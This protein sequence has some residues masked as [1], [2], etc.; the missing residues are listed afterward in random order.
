M[1]AAEASNQSET[2]EKVTVDDTLKSA[3]KAKDEFSCD[4]CDFTSNWANGLSI[5]MTRKHEKVEQLDGCVDMEED[6]KYFSSR[7]YWKEGRIG[8]AFQTYLD[9][10]DIIEKSDLT[11]DA[12]QVEKG[13]ALE[14]RKVAFG[15]RHKF[16]PPW[17][18]N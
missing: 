17:S 5:H 1:P 10:I 2:V 11:E 9:V 18:T 6:D 13:K 3:E 4:I 12:K 8:T 15:T 7:H 16:F 14:A